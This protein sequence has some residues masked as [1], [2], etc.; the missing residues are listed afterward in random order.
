M[1]DELYQVPLEAFVA[2]RD[3]LAARLKAAGDKA[4]AAEVKGLRKPSVPAWAANQV[5][6]RAGAEWARLQAAAAGL[7][8]AHEGGDSSVLRRAIRE[9]REALLACEARAAAALAED[10][11]A[12][13]PT[14]LRKVSGTL[15]A[16][17][18]AAPG[19]LAGRL[20]QEMAPPGFDALAGLALPQPPSH[21]RVEPSPGPGED[22]LAAPGPE[23][24]PEPP[25][26]P[27][28]R[29]RP[30]GPADREAWAAMRHAL[31]PDTA[32]GEH[33]A[34]IDTML[35]GTAASP[36]AALVAE[37]RAAGLLGF[38]EV[39]IRAYAEGCR[40]AR[41]GYL[42][43]WYVV[44]GARRT[45]VGRDLVRAAEDWARERG[46][47]EFASATEEANSDAAS[48]HRA[49]GFTDLDLVRCFRKD[50]PGD[51]QGSPG[52]E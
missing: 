10:G 40:T 20:A 44:P 19:A 24:E 43:G 6:W 41:V 38:A 21:E 12:A 46:C 34:E 39:S 37:D 5:V 36:L 47:S 45:G 26:A 42:E 50:L 16:L 8:R 28:R 11:H 35:A 18:H 15:L 22:L 2:A 33:A 32:A 1:R 30:V 23:P 7:R 27:R 49:L 51:R 52:P 9:Q 4:G 25:A 3:A 31:W 13:P 14:V 29:V 48:A 17:A